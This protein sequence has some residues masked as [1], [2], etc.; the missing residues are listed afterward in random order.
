MTLVTGSIE[1][2][3]RSG[4]AGSPGPIAQAGR[5]LLDPADSALASRVGWDAIADRY[6]A[7]HGQALG[8]ARLQWGPEG[9]DEEGAGL[10][11]PIAGRRVLE[12]GCGAGQGSRWVLARGG[13]PVGVD[14]SGRMLRHAQRL[15]EAAG[16]R[17][18][19]VQ[20]DA[21]R[22]PFADDSFAVACSAYGALPFVPDLEPV[23]AEVARVLEPRGRWVFS[24]THPVRWCFDDDPGERGLVARRSYFDRRAYVEADLRGRPTYVEH[25]HTLGDVVAALSATGFRLERLVEPEWQGDTP[26]WGPWSRLRGR[27]LPGTAVFSCRG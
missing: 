9:L 25:H 27:I 20:A 17:G 4:R 26:D 7:E 6:L 18:R 13:S 3:P 5:R 11:G 22:L 10:L 1:G 8:T 15:D 16:V 2:P 21:T 23:F 19:W 14:I 12:V 24:L